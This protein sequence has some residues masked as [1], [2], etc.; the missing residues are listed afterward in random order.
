MAPT[1]VLITAVD[2]RGH[3]HNTTL[4]AVFD[5]RIGENIIPRKCLEQL[6][7]RLPLDLTR[8]HSDK[9]LSDS[10]GISYTAQEKVRL[11]IKLPEGAVTED[12]CFYITESEDGH[13][14]GR[15]DIMLMGS[16][17]QKLR[18]DYEED[19]GYY[20]AAP[21]VYRKGKTRQGRKEWE[22]NAL[23]EEKK[24]LEAA[25]RFEAE[26]EKEQ[27]EKGKGPANGQ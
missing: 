21:T 19:Q 14:A 10:G 13:V 3:G 6:Q 7:G 5:D 25:K 22:K 23:E 9:T 1:T 24:K 4:K 20:S 18:L 16:L 2:P 27:K 17:K 15:H 12:L 8:L 26:W 11:L